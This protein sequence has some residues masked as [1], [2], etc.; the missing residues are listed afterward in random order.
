[1]SVAWGISEVRNQGNAGECLWKKRALS[2]GFFI[3]Q[4]GLWK[5]PKLCSG[6]NR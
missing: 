3:V 4:G 5:T 1:M 6:F 2:T